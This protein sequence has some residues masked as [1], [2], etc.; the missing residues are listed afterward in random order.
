MEYTK[1][2]MFHI[3]YEQDKNVLRLNEETR[4]GTFSGL[5]R[6]HKF[7]AMFFI[8]GVALIVTDVVLI[9]NFIDLLRQ[10]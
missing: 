7:I 8:V 10:I 1:D 3:K 5:L 2:M 6:E 4:K 9:N